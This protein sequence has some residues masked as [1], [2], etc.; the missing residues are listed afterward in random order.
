LRR[1]GAPPSVRLACQLR[2]TGDISVIPLVRTA[3]AVYR[4]APPQRTA[5]R[6][7]VVLFCDFRNREQVAADQ[8]PQDMLYMLTLYVDAIGA[9]ISG[10][11]GT[12]SYVELDSICAL[13][14]LRARPSAAA[15][16]ALQAAEAIERAVSNLNARLA[17]RPDSKLRIAISIHA[18]RAAVGE[19]GASDPPTMM[20][21]G[22]AIDAAQQLREVAAKGDTPFAVSEPVYAAAGVVPP[23]GRKVTLGAVGS[24][25]SLNVVLSDNVPAPPMAWTKEAKDGARAKLQRF[26][27]RP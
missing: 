25:P 3:R 21:I 17:L 19:V 16:G 18:G 5:E 8:L 27:A 20:A 11:G 1:I 4:Q 12:L 23:A 6:D 13:F 24:S 14:G 9:A 7:I 15:Q 26:L 22:E 10:A 2:P